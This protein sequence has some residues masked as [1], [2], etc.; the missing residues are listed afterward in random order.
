M[1]KRLVFGIGAVLLSASVLVAADNTW[2]FPVP[3]LGGLNAGD[4][5]YARDAN[6]LGN[7]DPERTDGSTFLPAL[8]YCAADNTSLIPTR[9]AT[10]DWALATTAGGG[11]TV[12]VNCSL[13]SWLQRT[14]SSKG[15]Q[16]N[17]I[18]ISYAIGT[19]LTAHTFGQIATVTYASGVANTIGSE[20]AESTTLGVTSGGIA[21]PYLHTIALGTPAY[22]PSAAN[23]ALNIGWQAEVAVSGQY[24]IYG[25]QVNFSRTDL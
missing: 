12:N 13:D 23:T 19:D 2:N 18:A 24:R 22:I 16:I 3:S 10:N 14:T 20:L 7:L 17:S 25:I 1:L 8:N 11:G 4:L 15:I 9:I 5:I 6:H 21:T